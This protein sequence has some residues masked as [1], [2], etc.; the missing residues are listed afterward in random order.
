MED[1]K[2]PLISKN[3]KESGPDQSY[4]LKSRFRQHLQLVDDSDTDSIKINIMESRGIQERYQK[5]QNLPNNDLRNITDLSEEVSHEKQLKNKVHQSFRDDQFVSINGNLNNMANQRAQQ[6]DQFQNVNETII[7][8]PH[9]STSDYSSNDQALTIQTRRRVRFLWPIFW[10]VYYMFC[11]CL[12]SKRRKNKQAK[13]ENLIFDSLKQLK[14]NKKESVRHLEKIRINPDFTSGQYLRE[15]L[16]FYLPQLCCHYIN[17]SMS[18]EEEKKFTE[19][20]VL[21][22]KSSFYFAH[23]MIFFFNSIIDSSTKTQEEKHL[24]LRIESIC[25]SGQELLFLS[26]SNSILELAKDNGINQIFKT[27][28]KFYRKDDEDNK[29]SPFSIMSTHENDVNRYIPPDSPI[30]KQKN[31]I[32]NVSKEFRKRTLSQEK[33]NQNSR[34]KSRLLDKINNQYFKKTQESPEKVLSVQ[35]D[36]MKILDQEMLPYKMSQESKNDHLKFSKQDY[37]QFII[38]VDGFFSTLKFLKDLTDISHRVLRSQDKMESLKDGLKEMNDN[39]PSAVYIPPD[40]LKITLND[41]KK[42][43]KV[44]NVE[45]NFG[46]KKK[47]SMIGIFNSPN[48]IGKKQKQKVDKFCKQLDTQLS[49]GVTANQ[50]KH[51]YKVQYETQGLDARN[52]E[53]LER[54]YSNVSQNSG[55]HD[56]YNDLQV[57]IAIVDDQSYQNLQ[58]QTR[59]SKKIYDTEEEK[60]QFLTYHKIITKPNPASFIVSSPENKK[61]T[62][63]INKAIN[64]YLKQSN[65]NLA[66]GLNQSEMQFGSQRA[67]DKILFRDEYSF[68]QNLDQVTDD[69]H[70]QKL[71][72]SNTKKIRGRPISQRPKTAR[73]EDQSHNP[74][75]N[76]E[77]RLKYD[78]S[79]KIINT[80]NMALT[81]PAIND[82]LEKGA[83]SFG[84][85]DSAIEQQFLVVDK[86]LEQNFLFSETSEQQEERLKIDSK[87]GA[88][89][90]WKV[91]RLIVKSGDDLRQEQFAMQIIELV[92]QLFRQK[93]LKC[94]LKPYEIIATGQGCGILEFLNDTLSID[95]VKRKIQQFGKNKDGH[96]VHIDFGFLLT[97]SPGKAFKLERAPFKLT[98]EFIEVMGGLNSQG[99]RRG[100]YVIHQNADKIL[101]LVEMLAQGQS[102]LPCFK[103]GV[104]V[105]LDGL[106]QRLQPMKQKS[107]DLKTQITKKMTKSEVAHYIDSLIQD[108]LDNWGTVVYDGW[109][110]CC[111]GIF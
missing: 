48:K 22:C 109:Q 36:K 30:K 108:S 59:Q 81:L 75:D 11:C 74:I 39:L 13:Y 2:E 46:P 21:M 17:N 111:Q 65:E 76:L 50:I 37:K 63:D 44:D 6:N 67:K 38:E 98:L 57:Q 95:Y 102:D 106:K 55:I 14:E 66:E 24:L 5:F 68:Y 31:F 12:F 23:R 54:R 88:L 100:F 85:S 33:E 79:Q 107:S 29:I 52:L 93:N 86:N 89:K 104:Q 53:G 8:D 99:F 25:I 83:S 90:T 82:D 7:N 80:Q 91:I 41:Y 49:K 101:T 84:K 94:W 9:T 103:Q 105:A 60:D 77:Q 47:S 3:H 110:Y 26:N 10:L 16:E 20:L 71:K 27:A 97:N 69:E 1:L 73:E 28:M 19:M 43:I 34:S 70:I 96:V 51:K 45:D 4:K 72:G 42:S 32:N 15:D 40:E 64:E 87:Y 18:P 62:I 58:N 56:E 92:D 78:P 61:Q 35:N